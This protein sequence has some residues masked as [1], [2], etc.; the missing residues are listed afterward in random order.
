M[1]S[2]KQAQSLLKIKISSLYK[3][4]GKE[5]TGELKLEELAKPS[6]F[7]NEEIKQTKVF[8]VEI[9]EYIDEIAYLEANKEAL[10]KEQEAKE[11]AKKE[12]GTDVPAGFGKP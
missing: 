8:V 12:S 3:A 11:R 1:E 5:V 6:I 2:F 10:Q 9:Q 4:A 7:D